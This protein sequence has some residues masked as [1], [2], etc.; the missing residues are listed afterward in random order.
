[1]K[2]RIPQRWLE[3]KDKFVH[4]LALGFSREAF[5]ISEM[6]FLRRNSIANL[7]WIFTFLLPF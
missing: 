7:F 2:I 6:Q 3:L 1:M 5:Q 4:C